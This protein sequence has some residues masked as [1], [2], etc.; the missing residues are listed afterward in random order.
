MITGDLPFGHIYALEDQR[1]DMAIAEVIIDPRIT[2]PPTVTSRKRRFSSEG[3]R[4]RV[5]SRNG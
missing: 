5:L 1:R 3:V 4:E 2:L